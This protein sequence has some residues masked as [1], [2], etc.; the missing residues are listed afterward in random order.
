MGIAVKSDTQVANGGSGKEAGSTKIESCKSSALRLRNL[1][2][3]NVYSTWLSFCNRL[4][5]SLKKLF[6][7]MGEFISNRP[8]T[9]IAFAVVLAGVCSVGFLWLNP[10]GRAAEL[11]VP[12][13]SK[14]VQDLNK[15]N[16]F[17]PLKHRQEEVIIAAKDGGNVLGFKYLQ[18]ALHVHKVIENLTGYIDICLT[19]SRNK[20]TSRDFCM[21]IN[22]LELFNFSEANFVNITG[23]INAASTCPGFVMSNGRPSCLNM[24]QMLAGINKSKS[25]NE[26]LSAQALKITYLVKEP[27]SD[28]ERDQIEAWEDAFVRKLLSLKDD[29]SSIT[30]YISAEKSLDDAIAASSSSDIRFFALT[31]TIMLQFASFMV[32]KLFRNPL[33]GHSLLAFG[34][35]FSV[36]LGILAGFSLAMLIQTPFT[37]IVGVLPF[38]VIGIGLDDMFI[39]VDHLDRQERHLKVPMTVRKVMSETGVTVTM[40][41]LTD[42]V[43]FAVSSSSQFPSIAYFCTYA[44]L[45][46]SCAFL[47]VVSVFVALLSFDVRRIKANRRNCLPV[48]YAPAPREGQ[49][50]WDEPRPQASNRLMERWG[51]FLMRPQT[52]ALVLVIS[53]GLLAGGIYATLHLDQEFDRSLLAKEDSYYKAYLKMEHEYF[54]LPTEVSLV[55]SGNVEYSKLSTQNE[56]IRLL[57][58]VAENKYFKDDTITWMGSFLKYCGDQNKTCDG[59]SFMVNLK[60]FLETW[61]FTYFKEDIKFGQSEDVIEAT[62]IILFMKSSSSSIYRKDAMLSIRKDLSSKSQL[63]VYLASPSFTFLEQYAVIASETIRN[64]TIASLVILVVTAPFLVNLSVSL[65]VF[66]GFVSLIFELF[67]MMWL[68][69]VS[70]NSISMINLVMAIGFAVDYSAH[71]AH[72][73][74]VAPGSSADKRVIDALTHVGASVLLG[75][76]STLVGIGMTALSK[77]EIFQIFFKMFFS[78]IFL[79]LLHGLC[80]LPVHLS[81]FHRFT[82]FTHVDSSGALC[83][84]ND[85][86]ESRLKEGNINPGLEVETEPHDDHMEQ[87]ANAI[88]LKTEEVNG[89]HFKDLTEDEHSN[90]PS[91]TIDS[92]PAC[93]PTSKTQGEEC[94]EVDPSNSAWAS[95]T[96]I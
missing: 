2:C 76:A 23:K 93:L 70:L 59:V 57:E 28:E 44:A 58:I 64:L 22:P 62:R 5:S 63:P 41:T 74:V 3:Q 12:Q 14:G 19:R 60:L 83:D 21:A 91:D 68:W 42:L 52:K 71:V 88:A 38:L 8:A 69:N 96:R 27:S 72:A 51:R 11:F 78:M 34:G 37:S 7:A 79:G 85:G 26:V 50:P 40:T 47:M 89:A 48:C 43:A 53:L 77:S 46:I 56:V 65:L 61:Q 84:G 1:S 92:H 4:H 20:A 66:F 55:L 17:F 73:F 39:I 75:G 13:N 94:N 67:G 31:F 29:L 82:M 45:T 95:D 25:P 32:G 24:P 16:E 33:T 6:G 10:E 9:V 80:I 36:G 35:T 87:S 49:P 54:R 18:E 15:A 86:G 81:I 90:G 30:L